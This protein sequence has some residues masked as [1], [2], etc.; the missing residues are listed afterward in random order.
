MQ[1]EYWEGAAWYWTSSE[2]LSVCRESLSPRF[3][4]STRAGVYTPAHERGECSCCPWLPLH[5]PSRQVLYLAMHPGHAFLDDAASCSWLAA[6]SEEGG[7]LRNAWQRPR[8]RAV[9]FPE[10]LPSILQWQSQVVP[11]ETEL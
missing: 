10:G 2:E 4:R 9:H 8:L 7:Q 11:E 5:S 6:G 1:G 3:D